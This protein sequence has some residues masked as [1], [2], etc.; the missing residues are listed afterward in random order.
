M[1]ILKKEIKPTPAIQNTQPKPPSQ[2]KKNNSF[3][4][5]EI[6]IKGEIYGNDDLIIEGSVEGKIEV[7]SHI[8]VQS[9]GNVLA[10]IY[11]KK[12]SISGK[13]LGNIFA[14]ESVEIQ[15]SGFLEGNIKSPKIIIL[16]GAHFK[17]NVDMSL[18]SDKEKREE[19][20]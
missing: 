17:G 13:V 12:V 19:N 14:E 8:T 16:E 4:S 18:N 7:K 6:K 11:A 1:G 5:H 10:E 3:I 9:T 2:V 20:P 15:P